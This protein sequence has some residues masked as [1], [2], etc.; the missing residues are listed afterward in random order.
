VRVRD[1]GLKPP[2]FF[3]EV[4]CGIISA[5]LLEQL[6]VPVELLGELFPS[7]KL[8]VIRAADHFQNAWKSKIHF[9]RLASGRLRSRADN[10]TMS[11]AG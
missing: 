6:F 8:E 2:Q 3:G 7:A 11:F 9:Q 10:E 5:G 4:T 1:A